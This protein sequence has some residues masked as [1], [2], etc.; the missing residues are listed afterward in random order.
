MQFFYG[1]FCDLFLKKDNRSRDSVSIIALEKL[2]ISK[3]EKY[4]VSCCRQGK[5]EASVTEGSPSYY[6]SLM[7]LQI[8]NVTKEDLGK[9]TCKAKNSLGETS[10]E[11]TL[12][13][14][15]LVFTKCEN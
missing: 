6:N 2:T 14:E 7:R 12:Y 15:F 5:F 1:T 3:Q 9:Y 4:K 10:G 11:I 8:K 13:G